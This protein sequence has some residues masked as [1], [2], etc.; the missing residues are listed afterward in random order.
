MKRSV[1]LFIGGM[2][3]EFKTSPDILYNFKIDD[4]TSP[5]AVKNTYSKTIS[6]P[7]TRNN[8]KI[9]DN[10]FNNDYRT[11]GT[12][13]DAAKKTEFSIYVDGELYETGYCKLDRVRQ[14]KHYYEYDVTLYGG[15]GDFFYNLS[16]KDSQAGED[17]R[18]KMSDLDY[19]TDLG[20][21]IN[22][23]TVFDAWDNIGTGKWATL[24]FAAAYNGLPDDFDADKC[25]MNLSTGGSTPGYPDGWHPRPGGQSRYVAPVVTSVTED[26]KVYETYGGYAVAE[27]SREYTE[28]EMRDFRSYLQRPVLNVSKAIEAICNPA[29]N[30]GYDVYLDPEWFSSENK[31]W[32]DLWVT[33]PML[34]TLEY[35]SKEEDTGVTVTIGAKQAGSLATTGDPGYFED[36][37]VNVGNNDSDKAFDLTV[38]VNLSIS[39]VSTTRNDDLVLCAYSNTQ[40]MYYA[41]AMLLQL[42]A[43]DAFGRP[44]AGSPVQ[45]ITSSYGARR[46]ADGRSSSAYF[47]DYGDWTYA[48]PYG[49]EYTKQGGTGFE[50]QSGSEY[51]WNEE[52]TMTAQNIPAGSTVKLLVTELWKNGSHPAGGKKVFYRQSAPGQVNTFTA[53]TFNEFDVELTGYKVSFKTGEGIRTGV[54]FT[55]KQ[56][57]DTE[58]SPCDFLLSYAKIFGLYFLKDPL[59]KKISILSRKNFFKRDSITDIEKYIDRQSV[60]VTPLAFN[61]KWY[62]WNLDSEGGEYADAYQKTYGKPYGNAKINVNYNF[63]RETNEVLDGNIFK[64]AVQVLE[65]SAAYCYVGE[66]T[67]QKSWQFP[68]Y[69]YLLFNRSDA[70]DT[71]EVEVK[72]SSTIDA[73][74]GFTTGYLYYD[75]FDKVQ[76]HTDGNSPADGTNVL[77]LYNGRKSFQ[78]G[79]TKIKYILSD[80]NSYM[81]VLNDGRPCWLYS[82]TTGDSQG[83]DICIFL[84]DIPHFS[85]FFEAGGMINKSLDFGKPEEVYV[86]GLYYGEDSTIYNQFWGGYISDLYSKDSRILKTKMLIKGKPSVDWLRRFYVFDNAVWRMTAIDDYNLA[87]GKLTTVTF[88]RVQ[89]V[90][91]YTSEV[92]ETGGTIALLI[93]AESVPESGGTT[94]FTVVADSGTSWYIQYPSGVTMSAVSGTGTYTGIITIPA[95]EG[96]RTLTFTVVSDNYSDTKSITQYEM[97]FMI[98]RRDS[99]DDMPDTGGTLPINVV[100]TSGSWTAHTD[101]GLIVT[102]FNPASGTSTTTAGT[103]VDVTIAANEYS[104]RRTF[105][106]YV[107]NSNGQRAWLY[108]AQNGAGNPYITFRPDFIMNVPASGGTYEV[109]VESNRNW[110]V[111]NFYDTICHTSTTAGTPGVTTI[112]VVV[113]PNTETT[114]RFGGILFYLENDNH[115]YNLNIS[116]VGKEKLKL[117]WNVADVPI[118]SSGSTMRFEYEISDDN[119]RVEPTS[120]C[121][122]YLSFSPSSGGPTGDEYGEF[123]MTTLP[124]T[125]SSRDVDFY[126]INDNT[127][128]R[129]PFLNTQLG[130]YVP[131][132]ELYFRITGGANAQ[133]P[134]SGGT[135][136]VTYETNYPQVYFIYNVLSSP[137]LA[138][139]TTLNFDIDPNT[140]DE[141]ITRTINFYD[142]P[143]GNHL[144]GTVSNQAASGST[145]ET[146][147]TEYTINVWMKAFADANYSGNVEV[148]VAE[149]A[150]GA[151]GQKSSLNFNYD[152]TL[153]DVHTALTITTSVSPANLHMGMKISSNPGVMLQ[154]QSSGGYTSTDTNNIIDRTYVSG[155]ISALLAPLD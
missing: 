112:T 80:D 134:A 81:S 15:L 10:F 19:G 76:L 65:R 114:Q 127:E 39:G 31:Y 41:S 48:Q 13:F 138:T 27:L 104:S 90:S 37:L 32:K 111:N 11:T 61:S 71:Y 105:N 109:V 53:Y 74:K 128:T 92:S 23:E 78:L 121:S 143:N 84:D 8:D 141:G 87:Q 116:Q 43:Y 28:A 102:G 86:P 40:S 55:Q 83:N 59:R 68:G 122:S 139:G 97:L 38:G 85:R 106:L 124:N 30:G 152:G 133:I 125:G 148:Y 75:M 108:A 54:E 131:P 44:V 82:T 95:Y 77:L 115:T 47:L 62:E 22:K 110:T 33:M 67:V 136:S 17:E 91:K 14:N 57:L 34:S 50:H 5:A 25:L 154:I 155:E 64:G 98:T 24:N 135:W 36:Y 66:D 2:E 20:F 46:S 96:G 119:W 29:N 56:L 107:E 151:T 126:F 51:Q 72:P 149:T 147:G 26:G 153:I 63:N 89:D 1:H 16:Y 130:G 60:E 150:S 145:P 58:Y 4:V 69:N 94:Q 137:V 120:A 140:G 123:Y 49:T 9:F 144:G 35:V 146:G 93:N 132:V 45:Y 142:A 88:V 52:I 7:S 3:V 100:C 70:T 99:G 42:V 12:N 18:M 21:K 117:R 113:E 103:D 101:Y 6:I 73:F 79:S 129:I 118:P